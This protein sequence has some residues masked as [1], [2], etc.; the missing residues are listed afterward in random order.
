MPPF[1]GV[2]TEAIFPLVHLKQDEPAI[3]TN[4][5]NEFEAL[6]GLNAYECVLVWGIPIEGFSCIGLPA[7][8]IQGSQI[9][10]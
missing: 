3:W 10:I 1:T 5:T 9:K 6:V 7:R 8:V 4:R 2:L